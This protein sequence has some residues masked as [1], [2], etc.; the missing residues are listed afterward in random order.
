MM[1][2]MIEVESVLLATYEY[3]GQCVEV[4]M[5][6]PCQREEGE[7][8]CALQITGLGQDSIDRV[9]CGVNGLQAL[10]LALELGGLTIRKYASEL[11]DSNGVKGAHGFPK[12]LR[13]GLG[14]EFHDMVER[15][16]DRTYQDAYRALE[17]YHENGVPLPP[18]FRFLKP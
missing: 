5:G 12:I 8:G 17:A 9:V 3:H 2:E 18:E 15:Y 1:V 13:L 6:M 4:R 11:V 7:W 16:I 10:T 14:E